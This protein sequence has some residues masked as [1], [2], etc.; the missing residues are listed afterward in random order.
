MS[1]KLPLYTL[2][3]CSSTRVAVCMTMLFEHPLADDMPEIPGLFF[4][5]AFL[6]IGGLFW[7]S[8]SS[9]F[10]SLTEAIYF[11]PLRK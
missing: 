4:G 6:I 7:K 8:N 1:L 3:L 2:G 9:F 11:N 10:L 5:N